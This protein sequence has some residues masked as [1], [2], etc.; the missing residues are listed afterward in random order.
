MMNLLVLHRAELSRDRNNN[1]ERQLLFMRLAIN[2]A[3]ILFTGLVLGGLSAQFAIQ[4]TYGIGAIKAGVWSAW[5]FVGGL[6]VDPYTAARSTIE[7]A[8]PLG[9]AEGLTFEAAVDEEGRAL[10]RECSYQLVGNTPPARLWTL[11][12]HQLDGAIIRDE[13]KAAAATFSGEVVRKSDYSLTI[14]VGDVPSA[15]NWMK[16]AGAGNFKFIMR[17]YDTPITSS[18]GLSAPLMPRI[19]RVECP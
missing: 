13:H 16:I 18:A 7:G 15:G 2:I 11:T 12:A 5:P 14:N 4:R 17:L 3:I 19:S 10:T 1:S 8:V 9:A 6:E